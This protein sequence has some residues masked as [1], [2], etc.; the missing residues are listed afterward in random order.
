MLTDKQINDA[1]VYGEWLR[2]MIHDRRL[3][4]NDRNR[5]S[6]S[7]FAIA[8]EHHHAI[9]VLLEKHLYA[10]SY[11]LMRIAFDAY[12]RGMWLA[13]CATEEQ[14]QKFLKGEKMKEMNKIQTLVDGIEQAEVFR[15]QNLSALKNRIWSALCDYTHTGGRQVQRWNTSDGIEPNYSREEVLEVLRFSDIVVTFSTLGLINLI[16]DES[17]GQKLQERFWARSKEYALGR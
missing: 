10:S 6:A 14:V 2:L 7:C 17:L 8:G 13:N 4:A 1:N 15:D 3:P 9:I 12:V 5:A 11:A 16:K